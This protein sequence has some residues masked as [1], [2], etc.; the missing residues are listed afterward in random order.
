MLCQIANAKPLADEFQSLRGLTRSGG[1]PRLTR[2]SGIRSHTTVDGFDLPAPQEGCRDRAHPGTIR[3]AGPIVSVILAG[4]E[5]REPAPG[6][7]SLS[8]RGCSCTPPGQ[9]PRSTTSRAGPVA[10]GPTTGGGPHA[11]P[12]RPAIPAWAC[13]VHARRARVGPARRRFCPRP[14][15]VSAVMGSHGVGGHVAGMRS[16]RADG[17]G[18]GGEGW[19]VMPRRSWD[20]WGQWCRWD[21]PATPRPRE[22]KGDI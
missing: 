20:W 9:R 13:A 19:R 8:G 15:P 14:A 2:H 5:G 4:H 11:V 3:R 21:R 7:R 18:A 22:A 12:P 10:W 6:P 17:L 16:R 1:M